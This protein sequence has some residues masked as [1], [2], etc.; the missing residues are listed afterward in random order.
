[1]IMVSCG[2]FTWR[3]TGKKKVFSFSKNVLTIYSEK[4]S[5]VHVVKAFFKNC[6]NKFI[7]FHFVEIS[8]SSSFNLLLS[9]NES[10][11]ELNSV[12]DR[13]VPLMPTCFE[14]QGAIL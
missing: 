2:K 4:K 9:E 1:M 8:K 11:N 12:P 13:G 7:L 14:G 5:K 10:M 3:F 6:K